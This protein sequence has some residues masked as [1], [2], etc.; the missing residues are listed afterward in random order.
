MP[1]AKT[2]PIKRQSKAGLQSPW[3]ALRPRR[4]LERR[5]PFRNPLVSPARSRPKSCPA[6]SCQR[7]LC[8]DPHH[9]S[10]LLVPAA[11]KSS[12]PSRAGGGDLHADDGSELAPL[13]RTELLR[14]KRHLPRLPP[15]PLAQRRAAP[16]SSGHRMG[17]GVGV[18]ERVVRMN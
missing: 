8:V 1:G 7:I 2:A 18:T 14:N 16:T 5:V 11:R 10:W 4:P 17:G 15:R 3:R 13:V 9:D 12:A 6:S